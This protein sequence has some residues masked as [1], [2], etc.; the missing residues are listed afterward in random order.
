LRVKKKTDTYVEVL[1]DYEKSGGI[2]T[3][4]KE[5]V[6]WMVI[7]ARESGV[8]VEEAA[9]SQVEVF[10]DSL[11]D[12]ISIFGGS[13]LTLVEVYSLEGVRLLQQLG[14]ASL[15]LGGLLSGIYIVKVDGKSVQKLIKQ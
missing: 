8:G 5:T 9:T 14:T 2:K 11:H 3:V 1:K 13:D 4:E 6:G 15:S 12:W 7:G 10:Y